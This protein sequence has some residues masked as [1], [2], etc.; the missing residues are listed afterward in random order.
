M[1]ELPVALVQR[2]APALEANA[3]TITCLRSVLMKPEHG[4]WLDAIMEILERSAK[5]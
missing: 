4:E 2:Y 5:I 1:I 3:D